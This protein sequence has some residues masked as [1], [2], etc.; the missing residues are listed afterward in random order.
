VAAKKVL[1]L[2]QCGADHASIAAVLRRHF[3]AELVSAD[4]LAEVQALLGIEPY[5]LILVNRVLDRD[6]SSGLNCIAA[7]QEDQSLAQVPVMLVS[8]LPDAQAEAVALGA[9]P[10]FGKAA[11]GA[12]ATL[13]Q[14][15]AVLGDGSK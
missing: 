15:R 8:N 10:G 11:L 7:L 1:S 6:H 2:G 5:D 12:A 14:L 13:G 4:S 3:D 9:R